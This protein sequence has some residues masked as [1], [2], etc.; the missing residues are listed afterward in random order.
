MLLTCCRADDEHGGPA[1][2]RRV[3][4]PLLPAGVG[5]AQAREERDDLQ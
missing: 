5:E 4:V 3:A 2:G 1:L